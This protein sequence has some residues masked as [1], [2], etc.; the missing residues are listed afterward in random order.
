MPKPQDKP[1]I[2]LLYLQ[3]SQNLDDYL[4]SGELNV[5]VI[6]DEKHRGKGYARQA[7]Q[8]AF[9]VA[10]NDQNCHR[11]QAILVDTP[12]KDRALSLFMMSYVVV[13]FH[14]GHKFPH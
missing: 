3:S 7:V 11:V 6:V 13:S 2:G 12:Y 9:Q 5:G 4:R 8:K 14:L 10:F 1:P